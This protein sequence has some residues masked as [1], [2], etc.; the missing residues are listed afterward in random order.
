M[1]LLFC[2]C[3]SVKESRKLQRR[4]WREVARRWQY[5]KGIWSRLMKRETSMIDFG[6]ILRIEKVGEELWMEQND[7]Q[8]NSKVVGWGRIVRFGVAMY[9]RGERGGLNEKSAPQVAD[10]EGGE[11]AGR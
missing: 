4:G 2:W 9:L 3:Y 10:V 8:L 6:K 11:G 1:T 5:S 7:Q